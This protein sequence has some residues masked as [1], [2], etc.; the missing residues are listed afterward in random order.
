MDGCWTLWFLFLCG[1]GYCVWLTIPAE[2]E[3]RP[4]MVVL[5]TA[6]LRRR[7]CQALASVRVAAMALADATG[8]RAY[9]QA[10]MRCDAVEAALEGAAVEERQ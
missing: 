1:V 4:E 6:D 3:D 9:R 5:T 10:A 2:S 7:M 8:S